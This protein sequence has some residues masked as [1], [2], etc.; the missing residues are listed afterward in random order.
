MGRKQKYSREVWEAIDWNRP[1][2]EIAEQMNCRPSLI[3]A[4]AKTLGKKLPAQPRGNDSRVED[5][6]N[7]DWDKSNAKIA[8]DLGFSRQ[9]I[10]VM[11]ER[12]APQEEK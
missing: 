1:A 11:R 9:W 12:Y 5:W 10:A 2:K 6:A 4:W 8:E 7:V 3:Y